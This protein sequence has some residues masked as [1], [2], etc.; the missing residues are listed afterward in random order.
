[1]SKTPEKYREP[2]ALSNVRSIGDK[3]RNFEPCSKVTKTTSDLALYS[4]N[5][6]NRQR[7]DFELRQ[8]KR[9]SA[10]LHGSQHHFQQ[11]FYSWQKSPA[12]PQ[13]HASFQKLH[14]SETAIPAA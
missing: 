5:F 13:R 14:V 11:E 6:P 2:L 8:A 9:A 4:P 10:S 12:V 3:P 7:E 1:M